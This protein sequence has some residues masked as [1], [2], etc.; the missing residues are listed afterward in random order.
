[1]VF[2]VLLGV[3]DEDEEELQFGTKW[4]IMENSREEVEVAL[5]DPEGF[6]QSLQADTAAADQSPSGLSDAEDP[7]WWQSKGAQEEVEVRLTSADGMPLKRNA[8][9]GALEAF[10]SEKLQDDLPEVEAEAAEVV[11]PCGDDY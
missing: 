11:L 2:I 6:L 1:M 9:T 8:V 5:K 10:K 3:A 7:F 4:K